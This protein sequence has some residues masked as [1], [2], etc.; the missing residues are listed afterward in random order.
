MVMNYL[1]LLLHLLLLELK[2]DQ[3]SEVLM[4]LLK[5]KQYMYHYNQFLLLSVG[6]V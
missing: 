6:S 3:L 2:L 4:D 1:R 5:G